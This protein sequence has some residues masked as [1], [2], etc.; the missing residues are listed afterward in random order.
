VV[1]QRNIATLHG[2]RRIWTIGAIHGEAEKLNALHDAITPRLAFGD[3]LVYL[4]NY[5][6][7]GSAQ[8]ETIAEL[9][10][11]RR[12]FLSIPPYVDAGDVVFLRGAQEEMWQKLLQLQFSVRPAEILEW[13]LARGVGATLSA[14]GGRP[15]DGFRRAAE[16][17]V[18][19]TSWTS[20]LRSAMR[21]APGHDVLLSGLK[22]AAISH[23]KGVLFVSS[24]L[25]TTQSLADQADS[26]WWAGRSFARI[27]SPYESFRRIVRGYDPDHHGFFETLDALTV[28][29]GC[30]FGGTLAAVCISPDGEVSERV[31][32]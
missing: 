22:R 12:I 24:G 17:T 4:G 23:E 25:D 7:Y 31:E 27:D 29:G 19:L 2:A 28:D 20:E 26:F 30:G 8:F 14:Y 21:A 15:V 16:G 11:F 3:R 1:E 5:L 13:M 9:L 10:R 32:I 6:G 18:A